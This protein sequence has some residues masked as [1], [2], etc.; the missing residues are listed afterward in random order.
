MTIWYGDGSPS[1]GRVAASVLLLPLAWI[2]GWGMRVRAF[3][4]GQGWFGV[5]RPVQPVIVVGNLTV[6]GTGKTPFTIWLVERLT[7]QGLRV[8][9]VS[10]GYGRTAVEPRVVAPDSSV[11]D[12]GDEPLLI[13]RRTHA[14]VAVA[15]RRKDAVDLLLTRDVDV[16]VA[17][18]GL[19]H[20]ALARDAELV[21]VDGMRGLGNGAL[22]PAGPLREPVTRL[23][24]VSA[25][26]VNDGSMPD[27]GGKAMPPPLDARSARKL[28]A[29]LRGRPRVPMVEM[30]MRA[31]RAVRLAGARMGTGA[32]ADAGAGPEERSLASFAD[33]RVHAV[34]GIGHPQ[35]F[36]SLLH[37]MGI[38]VTPHAFPDHH[39]Y[40]AADLAFGDDAPILMTEKDAVKCGDL[41]HPRA[42]FVP[43]DAELAPADA[44]TL[45]G[46]VMDSIAA[47]RRA[48]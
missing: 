18:D 27:S 10:R 30:R 28:A 33:Q 19:Q 23:A 31:S 48:G 9:V 11:R 29:S 32:G 17:D 3:A 47:R 40:S 21:V 20:L 34:A 43:I 39:R 24:S 4:Y 22:L 2:Y 46:I 44:E 35:R 38:G 42:W 8:G 15:A 6:G 37:G 36:F 1:Y 45:L 13:R 41:A 12:V 5:A 14:A 26:I 25:I 16:I 7:S